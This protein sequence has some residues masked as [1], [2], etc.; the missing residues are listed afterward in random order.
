MMSATSCVESVLRV[1]YALNSKKL[2]AASVSSSEFEE[3]KEEEAIASIMEQVGPWCGGGLATIVGASL[4]S[5]V[6]VDGVVFTPISEEGDGN[7]EVDIILHKLTG[8]IVKA[9]EGYESPRLKVI[10]KIMERNPKVVIVDQLEN[11]GL[12]VSRLATNKRIADLMSGL[13]NDNVKDLRSPL[14]QPSFALVRNEDDNPM[15]MMES[16]GLE[17][18]VIC[19]PERACGV[20]ESHHMNIVLD[21]KGF[22]GIPRPFVLQQYHNHD[23]V[24]HK[25]YVIGDC[26]MMFRRPSLPNFSLD[27]SAGPDSEGVHVIPFDS[28]KPYPTLQNYHGRGITI[29]E[30]ISAGMKDTEAYDQG[31][32]EEL[33]RNLGN[34][35]GLSLFGFDIIVPT[36]TEREEKSLL[37]VDVNFFPS[38]KEVPDFPRL[39]RAHL[40]KKAGFAPFRE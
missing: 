2:R 13:S 35:F 23:A 20:A 10:T 7:E 8:D 34:S 40:R 25:V 19:K 39:L 11:V 1:G 36:H 16:N 21:E 32:L 31:Q 28:R 29:E 4:K 3:L 12:V 9:S 5:S 38:Y 15:N 17:F 18:P 33:A 24:F 30:N 26:V 6:V 27:G 22:N 14:N 37:I